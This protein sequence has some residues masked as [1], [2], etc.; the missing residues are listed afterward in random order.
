MY[1]PLAPLSLS[2]IINSAALEMRM[3]NCQRKWGELLIFL[4]LIFSWISTIF[5]RDLKT[6]LQKEARNKIKKKKIVCNNIYA[7]GDNLSEIIDR[8]YYMMANKQCENV[9]IPLICCEEISPSYISFH[10]LPP[11]SCKSHHPQSNKVEHFSK[12]CWVFK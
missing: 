4:S 5:R 10:R 3:I 9:T 1:V 2:L 6:K 11:S 8:T 7:N 12:F